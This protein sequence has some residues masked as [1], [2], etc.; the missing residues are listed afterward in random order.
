[1]PKFTKPFKA[2]VPGD[3]YATDFFAGQDC[4]KELIKDA[5][6]DGAIPKQAA[7]AKKKAKK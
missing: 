6:A 4:P 1:M 2:V 3:R 7:P 5:E